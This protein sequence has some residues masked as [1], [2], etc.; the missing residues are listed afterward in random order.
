LIK[1]DLG[2]LELFGENLYAVHSIEYRK[3]PSHF[4]VFGIRHH[5]VWLSWE[6]TAFTPVFDLL[7]TRVGNH[8][9]AVSKKF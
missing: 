3:L 5:D 9:N 6:E 4:F 7:R 1:H 2:D 8:T